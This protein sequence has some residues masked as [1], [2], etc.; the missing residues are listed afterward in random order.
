MVIY[1]PEKCP[2]TEKC[3]NGSCTQLKSET[4]Y[5]CD[6]PFCSQKIEIIKKWNESIKNIPQVDEYTLEG[7][8]CWR[9]CDFE[10]IPNNEILNNDEL[11]TEADKLIKSGFN[12]GFNTEYGVGHIKTQDKEYSIE[13]WQWCV[14]SY[15][16]KNK[17]LKECIDWIIEL[18]KN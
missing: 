10:L 11:Y 8:K 16:V 7:I 3:K 12:L 13:L 6:H 1:I 5:I 14:K 18:Y 15:P 9:I 4:K 17:T 2:D